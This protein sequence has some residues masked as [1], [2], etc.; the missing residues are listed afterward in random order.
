LPGLYAPPE[1]ELLLAKTP[2]GEAIGCIALKPLSDGAC[3]IKRLYV[4]PSARG[5]GLGKALAEA[6]IAAA[7]R[8][9]YR[10]IKLDTLS[11]MTAATTLYRGLGFELI[12]DYGTTP[13]PGLLCF[14][15]SLPASGGG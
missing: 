13:Y 12:P 9:G 10:E 4:R 1:G 14:G 3:E 6:I 15:K 8:I 11:S 2:D 7:E 5:L